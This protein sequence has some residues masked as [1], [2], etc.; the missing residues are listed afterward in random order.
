[1]SHFVFFSF[2]FVVVNRATKSNGKL[3]GSRVLDCRVRCF[4]GRQ[5][6]PRSFFKMAISGH[7]A[8]CF[9]LFFVI[10]VVV[11]RAINETLSRDK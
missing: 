10:V 3:V 4:R 2:C 5:W 1:M 11:N 7:A 8:F 9:V 6:L